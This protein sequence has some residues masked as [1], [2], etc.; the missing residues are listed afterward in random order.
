MSQPE[1]PLRKPNSA[2]VF[3]LEILRLI[4]VTSWLVILSWV[5]IVVW[6]FFALREPASMK[7]VEEKAVYE[8]AD[9][10]VSVPHSEKSTG[11]E[12]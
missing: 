2:S 5:G 4:S 12:I 11:N 7:A 3:A 9:L 8:A 6:V 10:N 1:Q